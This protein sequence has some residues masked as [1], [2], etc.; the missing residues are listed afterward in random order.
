MPTL[1]IKGYKAVFVKL[2]ASFSKALLM[3]KYRNLLYKYLMLYG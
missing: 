1:K 3:Y 2:L